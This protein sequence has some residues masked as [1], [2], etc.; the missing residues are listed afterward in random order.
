MIT[1][2]NLQLIYNKTSGHCHFCGD[3]VIFGKYG[4]K[5]AKK[6]SGGWEA[7]HIIQKGKGGSN[8]V[9]NY[10]P[11]CI[12]CNRLRWHRKGSNLRELIFLGLIAKDEIKK[13]SKIGIQ[14][15]KL[16]GRRQKANI[17]RRRDA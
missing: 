10:L 1:K 3:S 7:D 4:L 14:I 13:K 16:R 11:S 12:K 2:Q 6:I 15:L 17:T 5:N 9:N 8:N